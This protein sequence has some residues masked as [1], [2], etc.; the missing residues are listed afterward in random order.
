MLH[1]DARVHLHEVVAVAL[2]DA[3]EGRGGVELHGAAEA[4]GLGLHA[5]EHAE[6]APSSAAAFAAC[7]S[8]C[9]RAS[10]AAREPLLGDRDLDQLLLVHLQRAVAA[11]ER[12]APRAVAEDLDLV[13]ARL[14]DVELDQHVLVVADAGRLHLGEDLAHQR[15]DR[16]RRRRRCAVPCRRRRRSPSGGSAVPGFS[17]S[18]R[19]ASRRIVSAELV[20]R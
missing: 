19:A 9:G 14:L 16:A 13:V 4:L 17:A 11:A 20:D 6:V 2:D 15:R 5:L 3:L 1:L 18:S 7:P 8:A 10:I 12:D